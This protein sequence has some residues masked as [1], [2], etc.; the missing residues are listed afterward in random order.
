MR[1]LVA[2]ALAALFLASAGAAKTVPSAL[3]VEGANGRSATLPIVVRDWHDFGAAVPRRVR[4]GGPY[5]VLT[6]VY[7]LRLR[8]AT[9]IRWFVRSGIACQPKP[10]GCLMTTGRLARKIRSLRVPPIRG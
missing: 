1:V 2:S 8:K 9:R 6:P 3:I 7:K 10:V 5:L 4:P